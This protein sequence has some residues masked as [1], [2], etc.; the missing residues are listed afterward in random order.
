MLGAFFS[1]MERRSLNLKNNVLAL[2]GGVA[3]GVAGY[4]AFRWIAAQGFSALVLPGACVGIFAGH[5][6]S[7]SLAVSIACGIGAL[8]L[9]LYS[10]WRFAP[11]MKDGSLYYFLT[12]VYQLKPITWF[13]I[14]LG[15]A[16]GFWGPHR[17]RNAS[18]PA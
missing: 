15:A 12:H 8:G 5:F 16:V 17:N 18:W 2:V 6:R 10:E 11:F 14:A 4:L 9:G 3:G 7:R 1:A 13:M